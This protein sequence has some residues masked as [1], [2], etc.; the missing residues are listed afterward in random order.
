MISVFFSQLNC[1]YYTCAI[2][3]D[4]DCIHVVN[5]HCYLLC[6][7]V[8]LLVA[9]AFSGSAIQPVTAGD[10]RFAEATVQ[11][12]ETLRRTPELAS[13]SLRYTGHI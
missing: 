7:V 3:Y 8:D 10:H 12:H 5:S 9:D 4:I 2:N 11:M 6:L 13:M 1:I